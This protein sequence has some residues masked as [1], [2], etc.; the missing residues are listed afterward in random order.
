MADKQRTTFMPPKPKLTYDI[1]KAGSMDKLV[2]IVQHRIDNG[3]QLVGSPTTPVY[4]SYKDEAWFYEFFQA[5]IHVEQ[6]KPP[7]P[8]EKAI[9]GEDIPEKGEGSSDNA[10][11]LGPVPE[12]K[13]NDK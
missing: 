3:W 1:V 11:P 13:E 9:D 10:G 6:P 4:Y 8:P 12:K 2:E 7:P 5:M